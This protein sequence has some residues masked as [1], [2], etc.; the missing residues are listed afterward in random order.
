MNIENGKNMQT[1]LEEILEE[2]GMKQRKLAEKT[3]IAFQQ[4]SR[5]VRG[6]STPKP[7]NM[8]KIAEF[9]QKSV[10]EIFFN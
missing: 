1:K 4:I 5:Y 7:E 9:L 2:K 10:D 8:K 6:Y 3:G